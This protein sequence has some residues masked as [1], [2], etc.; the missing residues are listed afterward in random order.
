M[1]NKVIF[2]SED[3]NDDYEDMY[4]DMVDDLDN[5]LSENVSKGRGTIVGY[6]MI[7]NRSSHYGSI[8][9]AGKVGYLSSNETE[10]TKAILGSSPQNGFITI[11]E[12]DGYLQ[13]NYHDH[14]GIHHVSIKRITASR[15]DKF[16]S[17]LEIGTHDE[18]IRYLESIPSVKMKK[19]VLA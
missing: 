9:G 17:K 6:G 14:D 7:A 2:N 5:I 10:L 1:T 15:E 4:M 16:N 18:I 19:R 12:S 11:D 13:V 8:G 3:Y